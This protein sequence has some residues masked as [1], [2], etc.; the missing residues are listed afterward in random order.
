MEYIDTVDC[1]CRDDRAL[2][3]YLYE[4]VEGVLKSHAG[5]MSYVG[6]SIPYAERPPGMEF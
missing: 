5:L 1:A 6:N 2:F 3:W 4:E